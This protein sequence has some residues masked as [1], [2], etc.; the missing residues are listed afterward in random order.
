MGM[1]EQAEIARKLEQAF[2]TAMNRVIGGKDVFMEKL[3]V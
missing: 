3:M 1:A 2:G